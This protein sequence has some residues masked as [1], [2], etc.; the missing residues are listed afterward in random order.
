MNFNDQS[1]RLRT[2]LSCLMAE[3]CWD[4]VCWAIQDD[5]CWIKGRLAQPGGEADRGAV[6]SAV[7]KTRPKRP[8]RGSRSTPKPPPVVARQ[9]QG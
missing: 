9:G 6:S 8:P 3:R 1:L 7:A 5:S 2:A 4:P